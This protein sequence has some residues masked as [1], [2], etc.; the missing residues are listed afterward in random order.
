MR[1][2]GGGADRG[3]RCPTTQKFV[4]QLGT[5][6]SDV[7]SQQKRLWYLAAVFHYECPRDE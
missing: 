2:N 7:I 6:I 3:V 4:L 1:R 5:E